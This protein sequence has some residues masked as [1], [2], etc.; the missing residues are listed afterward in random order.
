MISK[1][2]ANFAQVDKVRFH[3]VDDRD[4]P[5]SSAWY[6]SSNSTG[7]YVGVRLLG[8]SHKLSLHT[9]PSCDGNDSQYGLTRNAALR[10]LADGPKPIPPLRR[11][12]RP[13]PK[14][15]EIVEVAIIDFP[16]DFLRANSGPLSTGKAK[17]AIQVA[18]PGHAIRA[19]IFASHDEPTRYGNILA[20]G[21]FFP[22][23]WVC[24]SEDCYFTL[25]FRVV[26]FDRTTMPM[27]PSGMHPL[28]GAP[29]PGRSIST[30]AAIFSSDPKDGEPIYLAQAMGLTVTNTS[31]E[32][33]PR[34]K[35]P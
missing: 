35:K 2:L 11:W 1:Q 7:L 4:R 15:N 26:P 10:E 16:T 32:P 21:G 8:N 31:M 13:S 20:K 29:K 18:E 5:C 3:I 9:G 25:S 33:S 12:K 14:P 22:L 17:I 23:Y 27:A 19:S 34:P 30:A 6:V 28:R 24:V